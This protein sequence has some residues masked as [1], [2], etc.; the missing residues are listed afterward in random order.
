MIEF[1]ELVAMEIDENKDEGSLLEC[2]RSVLDVIKGKFT[3]D[4][5]LDT[6][7]MF[8]YIDVVIFFTRKACLA[9]VSSRCIPLEFKKIYILMHSVTAVHLIFID[10]GHVMDRIYKYI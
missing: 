9:Q 6:P 5:S 2:F 3:Q 8:S 4:F 1:F 7:L 10:I